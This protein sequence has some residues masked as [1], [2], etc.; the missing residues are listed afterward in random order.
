[1]WD[2]TESA[3]AFAEVDLDFH[4]AVGTASGN[5]LLRSM[6]AVVVTALVASFTLSSPF[7]EEHEH[8][9]TVRGHARIVAAI[10]VRDGPAAPAAMRAI[11]GHGLGRI[12]NAHAGASRCSLTRSYV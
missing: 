12:A 2:A 1:M 10:V 7:R 11:I 4:R 3:R 5:V 6:S 9:V 8:E